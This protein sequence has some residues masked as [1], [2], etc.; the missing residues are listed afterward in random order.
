MRVPCC[1]HTRQ[2]AHDVLR[3]NPEVHGGSA[4]CAHQDMRYC[5]NFH[6]TVLSLTL[7]HCHADGGHKAGEEDRCPAE[8]QTYTQKCASRSCLFCCMPAKEGQPSLTLT[9]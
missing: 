2:A 7:L 9:R 1:E 5:C 4:H 3:S 6:V 8:A